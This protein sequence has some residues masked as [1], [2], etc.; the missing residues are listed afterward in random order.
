MATRGAPAG[1]QN[2]KKAKLWSEAIK[3]EI[4][5]LENGDLDKGLD[6]LARKLVKAGDDGDRFALEEIGNRIEG[7]VPQGIIGG[8]D[9]D[10]PLKLRMLKLVG[11]EGRDGGSG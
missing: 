1:N 2:A 6:R 10:P 9:D 8:E 4:A 11:P 3:R 7:K 5:R